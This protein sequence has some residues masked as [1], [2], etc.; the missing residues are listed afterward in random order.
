VRG[1]AIPIIRL[2]D[3]L[4]VSIQIALSDQLVAA[5][6]D[7]IAEVLATQVAHGLV[8]E[9]SGVDVFDSYIAASVRDIAEVARFMGVETIVAGLD[10]GMAITLVEMGMTMTGVR[11]A[12]D[13]DVAVRDLRAASEARRAN[14]EVL[15]GQLLARDLQRGYDDHAHEP[16]PDVI[17]LLDVLHAADLPDLEGA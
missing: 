12:L 17:D 11:T 9:V 3:L 7:D 6:K 2:E 14:D 13:L 15:L 4:I 5:L 10:A 16:E 8:I 1:R